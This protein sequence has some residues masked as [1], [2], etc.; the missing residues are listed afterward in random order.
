MDCSWF[1]CI[2]INVGKK[3][4]RPRHAPRTPLACSGAGPGLAGCCLA[5]SRVRRRRGCKYL[6]LIIL[7]YYTFHSCCSKFVPERVP[8]L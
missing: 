5:D 2:V 7:Y 8:R 1:D 3:R 6:S 4:V